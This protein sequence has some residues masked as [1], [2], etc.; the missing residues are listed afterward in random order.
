M[1]VKERLCVV[2]PVHKSTL[3]LDEE[4]SIKACMRHLNGYDCYLV[5]PEGMK[6]VSFLKVFPGLLLKPVSPPWLAS[7]QGYNRMKLS[8]A[9]YDLFEQYTH[10]LTYELDAY[11]FH[12]NFQIA[13]IFSFDFIGAPLFKGYLQA[14]ADAPFIKGCN[15]G[16]SVR[17]IK[18]CRHVLGSL[19]KYRNHWKFYKKVLSRFPRL[20]YQLNRI[21]QGKFEVFICGML[22]FH[23]E[24]E[25]I[26]ED[27]AWSQVIPRLFSHFKVA[28][29]L[30]ALKFSFEHNPERLM[31]LNGDEL[32]IGCHAWR[33]YVNFWG[34]YLID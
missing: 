29:S 3:T 10:L 26:N 28:D 24:N 17:N 5:H 25:H 19:D 32:P 22:G 12:T 34:E 9:F 23:F 11:I 7:V 30:S 13:N 2:I 21:T 33:K 16:F 8:L 18:S 4:R 20:S 6:V 14:P 31:T 1:V 27:L 15:S